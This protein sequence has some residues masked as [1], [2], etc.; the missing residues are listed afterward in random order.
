M[1]SSTSCPISAT[2][3]CTAARC[4]WEPTPATLEPGSLAARAY[5]DARDQRAPSPSVRVQQSLPADLRRARHAL[6]RTSHHRQDAL[7]EVIELPVDHAS[8]VRGNASASGVQVAA[9]S[10]V[11]ALPRFHRRGARASG[12]RDRR[13]AG[14]GSRRGNLQSRWTHGRHNRRHSDA[15]RRT[16]PSAR[17]H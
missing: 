16:Q 3:R 14:A 15:R 7:V 4:A 8:L 12:Q 11:A 2:S 17:A 9:E 13:R 10:P 6:H 5:G 1:P